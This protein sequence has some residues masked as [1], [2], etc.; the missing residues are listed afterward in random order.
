MTVISEEY[1][2]LY[3]NRLTVIA[4]HKLDEDILTGHVVVL[5]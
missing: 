2:S 5:R 4:D 3:H 1:R